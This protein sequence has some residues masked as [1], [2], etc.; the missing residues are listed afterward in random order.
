MALSHPYWSQRF[1]EVNAKRMATMLEVL[2]VRLL[3]SFGDIDEE[4]NAKVNEAWAAIS[5]M[6]VGEY[7]PL[8]DE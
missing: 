7:G 6:P 3:P 5:S 8:I 1:A 2:K 4:A